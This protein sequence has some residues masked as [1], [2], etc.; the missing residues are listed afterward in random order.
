MKIASVTLML[1]FAGCTGSQFNSQSSKG[2]AESADS[3]NGSATE[4]GNPAT[5]ENTQGDSTNE[6]S[7]NS[8]SGVNNGNVSTD[9][10][11]PGTNG[12]NTSSG[13]VGSGVSS[14]QN[15]NANQNNG[16]D[17]GNNNSGMGGST[18]GNVGTV[19]VNTPVALDTGSC[20]NVNISPTG[21]SCP[22]DDVMTGLGRSSSSYS[23]QCCTIKANNNRVLKRARCETVSYGLNQKSVCPTGKFIV[24]L[25]RSG[26]GGPSAANCCALEVDSLKLT[27][28]DHQFPK[29]YRNE[30]L[31]PCDGSRIVFGIGDQAHPDLDIDQIYCASFK[32]SN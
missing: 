32:L 1:F 3:G 25:Q 24:S 27:S 10:T 30:S 13:A 31:M 28:F 15:G 5:A 11:S 14:S 16:G 8:A 19:T 2:N 12:V 26:G 9:S 23:L 22:N 18:T 21:A 6:I 20:S 29:V 17:N 7:P 4:T